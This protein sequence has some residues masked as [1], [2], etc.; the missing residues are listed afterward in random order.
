[1]NCPCR[2]DAPE[3]PSPH[4]RNAPRE[5]QRLKLFRQLEEKLVRT[6]RWRGTTNNQ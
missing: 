1:M 2:A 3:D 6:P 5:R 4:D